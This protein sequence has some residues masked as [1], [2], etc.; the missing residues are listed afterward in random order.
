MWSYGRFLYCSPHCWA[1]EEKHMKKNRCEQ[2]LNKFMFIIILI[3]ITESDPGLQYEE[4]SV[5]LL[6]S[7]FTAHCHFVGCRIRWSR[8]WRDGTGAEDEE[9]NLGYF[10]HKENIWKPPQ[11]RGHFLMTFLRNWGKHL[12]TFSHRWALAGGSHQALD[13]LVSSTR[14]W[15]KG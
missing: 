5:I 10:T 6:L 15:E 7:Q 9:H 3:I 8:T 12:R 14:I 11:I 13:C 4:D 2:I 1:P